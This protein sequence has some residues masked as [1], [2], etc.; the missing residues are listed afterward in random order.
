MEGRKK[1]K[2]SKTN[3]KTTTKIFR[4]FPV[5]MFQKVPYMGIAVGRAV[6]SVVERLPETLGT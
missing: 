1:T 6:A 3:N 5:L 2:Q 4:G